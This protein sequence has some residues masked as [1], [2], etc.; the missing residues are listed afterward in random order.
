MLLT[1]KH[2]HIYNRANGSENLFV[3]ERN[4]DFFL[5]RWA[6]YISPIADT[7]A[8]CL[9]PNHFHFLVKIKEEELL[10]KNLQG[11]DKQKA[12]QN[13]EGFLAKEISQQ[14]SN[15][16]NSYTKSFNKVYNRK[17]SLFIP[18][19]K[20][21]EIK[22]EDYLKQ[23]LLYIHNNPAHHGFTSNALDWKYS[24]IHSY[25]KNP[26]ENIKKL[27]GFFGSTE[28]YIKEQLHFKSLKQLVEIDDL[29]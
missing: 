21:K 19:F 20:H 3:E 28:E 4:Y 2:Y 15:L 24:S 13:L 25:L 9:M 1:S 7:Y 6:Y 22:T 10:I 8:W 14:F 12:R 27:I 17:G 18:R 26:N 29:D 16:F 23:V 5:K 11:F